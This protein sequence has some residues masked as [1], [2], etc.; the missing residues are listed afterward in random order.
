MVLKKVS[1]RLNNYFLFFVFVSSF[2]ISRPCSFA[3]LNIENYI[4]IG[5]RSLFQGDNEEAIRRFNAVVKINPDLYQS[6]FFRG[7][8]K[9][10]LKDY[11]GA[12]TDFSISIDLHPYFTHAYHYRGIT[13]ERL[14][15]YNSALQDYNSAIEIDPV[16]PGIYSSRGFTRVLLNDTLGALEDFNEAILMDPNNYQAYLSRSMVWSMMDKYDLALK[17]CKK[18]I[19]IDKY[20]IESFYRRGLIYYY[21]EDYINAIDDFNFI[22]H[23]DSTNSRAFYY[24]ALTRYKQNDLKGAMADY[25]RVLEI[26]PLNALTFYNRAILRT[27]VGDNQGAIFDYDRVVNLNPNNIFA[28]YN[29]G[30]AKLTTGD[31]YGAITDFTKVIELYPGF[32]QAYFNRSIAKSRLYDFAG[33][34][35]DRLLAE[36]ISNDSLLLKDLAQVDSTYFDEIIELKANFDNGNIATGKIS[37]MSSGIKMKSV[38]IISFVEEK[39]K[40]PFFE[41]DIQ[42]MNRNLGGEIFLGLVRTDDTIGEQVFDT[43]KNLEKLSLKKDTYL[44]DLLEGILSGSKHDFNSAFEKMDEALVKNPDNYLVYFNIAGLKFQLTELLNTMEVQ[45]DFLLIADRKTQKVQAESGTPSRYFDIIQY[46]D[47]VLVLKPDFSPAYYNRA[48]VKSLVNDLP[49]AIYDYGQAISLNK[50]F[51][52]AYYNRGLINIYLNETDKGCQDLSKAGEL[53]LREAYYAISKYC[54]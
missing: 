40:S 14:N 44:I 12:R 43:D 31:L 10:N 36:K 9:F 1:F 15:N 46:F 19:S 11:I 33:A 2:F 18:A 6:Y 3:Q 47:R 35:E 30:G 42:K 16:N 17:D 41:M 27:Q 52:E 22:V 13:Q 7:V 34:H 48:Y 45:N 26:D 23:V 28:Y 32:T 24:R 49:G 39:Y 50:E 38:Y 53:G 25:D 21:M 5:K 54:R 4:E 20:N 51:Q 8:A 29:R 37:S